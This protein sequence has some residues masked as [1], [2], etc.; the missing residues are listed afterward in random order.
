MDCSHRAAPR[1]RAVLRC[2]LVLAACGSLVRPTAAAPPDAEAHFRRG[3]T[4]LEADEP[5]YEEAYRSFKLAYEQSRDYRIL[6][7]LGHAA[8][9]L[10]R[11][12]EAIQAYEEYLAQGGGAVPAEERSTVERALRVLRANVARVV[13]TSSVPD[14]TVIDSRVGSEAPPQVYQLER[15][16]LEIDLRAGTHLLTATAGSDRLEWQV[17][18]TPAS[19]AAHHFSFVERR[20]ATAE[21]AETPGASRSSRGVLKTAAITATG[22]GS[23]ALVAGA[24]TGLLVLAREDDARAQCR[25]RSTGGTECP[26]SA[27]RDFDAAR[28]FATATNVLL[29]SG[30]VLAVVGLGTLLLTSEHRVARAEPLQVLPAISMR[31]TGLQLTGSF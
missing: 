15:G 27:R 11:D 2:L 18:L 10:E 8:E 24:V 6:P 9:A 16:R 25:T 20:H 21:Q 4:L 29:V 13:I 12:G 17:T 7:S 5:D 22:V 26:E 30:G 23:A 28:S 14:L 31:S 19:S 3:A 1:S